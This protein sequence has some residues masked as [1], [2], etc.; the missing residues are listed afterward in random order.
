MRN[1][2]S[3]SIRTQNSVNATLEGVKD[4]MWQKSRNC[5]NLLGIF[6]NGA[7]VRGFKTSA[8]QN[9]ARSSPAQPGYVS[10]DKI[11]QIKP[12]QNDFTQQY[13]SVTLI[14]N[15]T[16]TEENRK[17]LEKWKQDRIA[18]MGEEEFNRFYQGM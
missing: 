9:A 5:T 1:L 15:R 2:I 17:A 12:Y 11:L 4:K 13:P 7:P 18:E 8:V 16:M 14:L 3:C 10:E 6:F